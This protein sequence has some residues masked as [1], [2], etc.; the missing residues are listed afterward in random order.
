MSGHIDTTIIVFARLPLPGQA[1]TR[2]VPALGENGAAA[3]ATRML[4]HAVTQ[5]VRADLGPVELCMTPQSAHPLVR[6]VATAHPIQVAD[7]G[8]GDLGERMHRALGRRLRTSP[9]ALLIGTDAPALDT[10]RLRE[11]SAALDEV[12][13]VFI[14]ALDG[15]YALIGL[16]HPE[17]RLLLGMTWSQSQVMQQTRDRLRRANLRWAELPPVADVDEPADLCHVP[18]DWLAGLARPE[19]PS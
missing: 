13:A 16:R 12:D 11:A 17:P 4:H 3:L 6:D 18:P 15:G 7:Q 19:T 9:K 10:V 5:A 14:P 2:L 8:P 1:K